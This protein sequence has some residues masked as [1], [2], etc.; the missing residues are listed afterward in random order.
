MDFA[1]KIHFDYGNLLGHRHL[2]GRVR[3]GFRANEEFCLQI[4]EVKLQ[5]RFSVSRI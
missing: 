2:S 3:T 5:F 1:G 4:V